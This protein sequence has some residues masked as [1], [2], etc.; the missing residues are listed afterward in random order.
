MEALCE[1]LDECGLVCPYDDALIEQLSEACKKFLKSV[2]LDESK[3]SDWVECY[4]NGR[5]L[6]DIE[7]FIK[8]YAQENDWYIFKFPDCVWRAL[9][10]YVVYI[11]INDNDDEEEKA[12]FS[13]SLQNQ[14]LACKGHWDSLNFQNYLVKL[15]VNFRDY[16]DSFEQGV[17]DVEMSF[18][19]EI[20]DG[21]TT[22]L[23]I[24]DENKTNLENMGKFTWFYKLDHF[25]DDKEFSS[26]RNAFLKVFYF[27]NFWGRECP[28]IYIHMDLKDMLRLSGISNSK[29]RKS[30]RQIVDDYKSL[31][32]NLIGAPISKSSIILRLVNDSLD[33]DGAFLDEKLTVTEFFVYLYYE[34]LLELK[35][36]ENG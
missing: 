32:Q 16:L 12:I 1:I 23:E 9:T 33:E 34:V 19:S 8:N 21:S 7:T 14:L 25:W 15:Y 3:F 17:G 27:L 5:F 29:A 13:C 24:E 2:D 22:S 18:I 26:G 30:L 10:F 28:S 4:R 31:E 36:R 20:F 6:T 35:L 11:A